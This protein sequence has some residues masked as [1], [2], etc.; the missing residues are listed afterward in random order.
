MIIKVHPHELELINYET[1]N[2]KESHV[3]DFTFEFDEEITDDFVKMAYFTKDGITYEKLIEDNHVDYAPEVLTSIGYVKI[4]VSCY[5]V[6]ND[7]IIRYNPTPLVKYIEEGSLQDA[8][9]SEEIT[10]S[11]KEQMEQALQDGLNDINEAIE[12]IEVD[13]G[14]AREMGDYA[15]EQG[16]Y[17]KEQGDYA[18][19]LVDSY[20]AT[21]SAMQ[22]DIATNT[23]NIS[24]NT[25]S[26]N[27]LSSRVS[28]NETNIQTINNNLS[29]YSL[30][31]ETGS[32]L[33]LNLDSTNYKIKALLKDKNGNTIYTSNEIDLP[34]ESVVVS[35]T[36]DSI[37]KKI[38][39]TLEGGSTIDIPV[40]DLVSGLQS[41]I[42]STNKLASDL[43]DDS[44]SSNKFVTSDEKN[45]WNNKSDFSGNYNDLSNKPNIPSA[46]SD[47]TDDST[48]R[49]VSDTEKS[50]WNDK[51]DTSTY[52]SKMTQIDTSL[53]N[54]LE[55]SDL[56]DYVKNTDYASSSKGG[57][58]K[59]SNGAGI[60][61]T[62]SGTLYAVEKT[63][64]DYAS[65]SNNGFISKGTLENV[66][67]AKIGDI[68]TVLDTING[69]VI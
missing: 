45:T 29:N 58:I 17:S 51:V 55:E 30:I 25:T 57:V 66:L 52:N 20:S 11:D 41:E 19:D 7:K 59:T 50:T 33:V 6:D 61:A 44:L 53:E 31:S 3:S 2:E 69:E 40:G 39:L 48:H 1:T 12:T 16:D 9:N 35:G 26:I 47:L 34:L 49:T 64:S 62:S 14:Y 23:S 5:K 42:T 22:T 65:F 60:Y 15:K 28:E 18:K 32:Q 56:T 27:N 54:K 24:S 8:E 10:P 21:L 4:G 13:S 63:Y 37:N 38:V 36:Y 67:N 43:V 46:L 68:N